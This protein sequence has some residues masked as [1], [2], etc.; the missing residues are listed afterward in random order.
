MKKRTAEFA[1]F[2]FQRV[3]SSAQKQRHFC[4]MITERQIFL[5][6]LQE[7][8]AVKIFLSGEQE[9]QRECGG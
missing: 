7:S 9:N 6:L 3:S 4:K 2:L 8:F 1:F 5:G